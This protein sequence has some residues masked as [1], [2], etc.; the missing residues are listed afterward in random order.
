MEM[1]KNGEL[2][3][4]GSGMSSSSGTMGGVW[5]RIWSLTMPNKLRFFIWKACRKAL[6]VRHNLESRR[7]SVANKCDLSGAGDEIEA[8]IFFL[9]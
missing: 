9:L 5:K 4:K 6:A 2:G 8:Y 3:G 7:I 1:M